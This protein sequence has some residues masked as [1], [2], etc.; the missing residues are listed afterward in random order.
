MWCESCIVCVAR[1]TPTYGHPYH[2]VENR[3]AKAQN[4]GNT[5]SSIFRT[6]TPTYSGFIPLLGKAPCKNARCCVARFAK[7]A[8]AVART[9]AWHH[10]KDGRMR[11]RAATAARQWFGSVDAIAW[12]GHDL[13][14]RSQR[15]H[16][17]VPT[18]DPLQEN[19]G[20]VGSATAGGS[21]LMEEYVVGHVE[22]GS[23]SDT[24]F[25]WVCQ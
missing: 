13:A 1:P 12:R 14:S 7:S 3:F 9:G 6:P 23:E 25:Y 10:P 8:L 16:R 19:I 20:C 18:S 11:V 2:T 15:R 24:Q 22:H 5:T 17:V 21:A 4:V